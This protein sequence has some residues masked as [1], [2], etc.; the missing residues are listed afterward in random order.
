MVFS[1]ESPEIS[2][3]FS[4]SHEHFFQELINQEFS[5]LSKGGHHYLDYTGGG[6][7]GSGQLKAHHEQL[8]E[9]VFGNPHSTNPTSLA[10]T[11]GAETARRKVLNFF[12][13]AD[14]YFCVFTANASAALKVVGEC[15]PWSAGGQYL[16][17]TDN[18][19]SV[20]GIREYCRAGG[21]AFGYAP[22]CSNNLTIDGDA[23]QE[24]LNQP[25]AGPRLFAY[26]AQ[27]NVSGV[28]HDLGWVARA[29]KAGWHTLLDAAAYVPTNRLDLQQVQPDF[30]CLSFY[31]MFG[32]PTGIGALL[33]RKSSFTT[34]SK[35]WFAGGNVRMVGVKKPEHLFNNDH[36][37]FE[38]GT[39][40][41]LG[42]PAVTTGLEFL[43][44]VGM[45]RLQARITNL[46]N[47]L[48]RRLRQLRHDNGNPLVRMYGPRDRSACG[49]TIILNVLDPAGERL[50]YKRVEERA[51]DRKISIRSGCFCNPGLDEVNSRISPEELEHHF[52]LVNGEVT[53][54]AMKHLSAIR[55]GTRV[56][57]GMATTQRDIDAFIEILESFRK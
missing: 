35:R 6:L 39:I 46:A 36:E 16:L 29:R 5:R 12:N 57:V 13:A 9:G 56:S 50:C 11:E 51:N 41:Y 25:S 28:K 8:T 26:P 27:S 21:A 31:K 54:D 55:G 34:L 19:N 48:H 23:L 10:A 42:L 38:N 17:L 24:R 1:H 32:Y 3:S 47:Y 33:I 15:F 45:D 7:Y 2:T 49:G 14:D 20:N 18:H 30:V 43:E 22:V 52:T 40:N 4:C 37:R 44:Y 53:Q